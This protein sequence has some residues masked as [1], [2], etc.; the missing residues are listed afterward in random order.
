MG[1]SKK[2]WLE[3]IPSAWVFVLS[4]A[5][6]VCL[7]LVWMWWGIGFVH[8]RI[9]NIAPRFVSTSASGV[10]S[11]AA[12][13]DH[14]A[15]MAEL[16]Q[17]GD[18]FGGANAFFAA[19]AGGLVLWAGVLQSRSLK[20]AREAYDHEKNARKQEQF[21]ALF[22]RLLDLSRELTERIETRPT[23]RAP[24]VMPDQSKPKKNGPAAL[25]AFANTIHTIMAK[26][27]ATEHSAI[28][29]LVEVYLDI[30]RRRPSALG[31]Y[32]RL[33]FQAFKLIEKSGL[34]EHIQ[35][36]YANIARGQISDGAVLLLALNGLTQNGHK[37]IRYI[38]QFGL[39]EHMLIEHRIEY[40]PSLLEGY[41]KRA[42]KGSD[43]RE[44]L[45]HVLEPINADPRHFQK[46]GMGG[47]NF[48]DAATEAFDGIGSDIE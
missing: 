41:R 37:F 21:E 16:G 44:A 13:L 24:I 32:F 26:R 8:S 2:S 1:P 15:V 47:E 27:Q 40:G 48:W 6:A 38:E 30:Y 46:T 7:W 17:S 43:E 29:D 5:L 25:D 42:F 36:Q 12:S 10:A 9:S 19:I 20:E 34:P 14:A 23:R 11:A 22:F 18:A 28:Y 31:P 4:L 39:L 3:R 35:I 33:L 45:S